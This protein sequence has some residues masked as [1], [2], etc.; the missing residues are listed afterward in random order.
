MFRRVRSIDSMHHV[1]YIHVYFRQGGFCKNRSTTLSVTE[2]TDDFFTN[3]NN[4]K[5]TLAVFIDLKKAFD[6][7]DHSI[8][9]KKLEFMG[10][11]GTLLTWFSNYLLNRSRLTIANGVIS[12]TTP[13]VCEVPQG[14]KLGPLLFISYINDAMTTVKYSLIQFYAD[15][16]VLYACGAN[17]DEA[18]NIIQPELNAFYKWCTANILTL[19]KKKTKLMVLGTRSK[20]KES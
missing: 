12:N 11:K 13:I 9:K 17:S 16:T 20:V 15:D 8:L 19:N 1:F 7:I 10:I 4:N 18:S 2:L 3:I 5:V 14:S 6:T